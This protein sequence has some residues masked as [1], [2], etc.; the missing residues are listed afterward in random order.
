MADAVSL[1]TFL[2]RL[3]NIVI[4]A[5]VLYFIFLTSRMPANGSFYKT[6]RLLL[7]GVLLFFLVEVIQVFRLIPPATFAIIQSLFGFIFLLLLLLVLHEVRK[8]MQAHD[9]L[10]RRKHRQRMADVE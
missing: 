9:H 3:A 7:L 8:G 1:L 4:A 6:I 5:Y 2:L 10:V